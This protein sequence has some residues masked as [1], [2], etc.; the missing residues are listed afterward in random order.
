[1]GQSL[2]P[3]P[4]RN[5]LVGRFPRG[6]RR[7]RMSLN[8][9][10]NNGSFH[11]QRDGRKEPSGILSQGFRDQP[12]Q[13]LVEPFLLGASVFRTRMLKIRQFNR[14]IDERTTAEL[15]LLHPVLQRREERLQLIL[16]LLHM[17]F[18][19]GLEEITTNCSRCFRT[20]RISSSLD[21]KCEYSVIFATPASAM[22]LSMPT[23]RI[24]SR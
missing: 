24:P 5:Q 19:R 9:R 2:R 15:R 16:T 10:R 14:R 22:I 1:M 21:E 17:S 7:A 20:A 12:S 4:R 8:L 18:D 11:K 23:D 3:F 6:I 13:H